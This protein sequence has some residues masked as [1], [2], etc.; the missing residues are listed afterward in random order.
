M[1]SSELVNKF[2]QNYLYRD[3]NMTAWFEA[4][5]ERL[6]TKLKITKPDTSY[7]DAVS[8]P[9]NLMRLIYPTFRKQ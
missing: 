9:V 8:N 2:A 5:G 7:N 6:P 1:C 4:E 3:I